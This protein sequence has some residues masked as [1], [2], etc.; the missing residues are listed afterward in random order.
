[1]AIKPNGAKDP[2]PLY[3]KLPISLHVALQEL[4]IKRL[5]KTGTEVNQKGLLEEA[6]RG[7]VEEEGIDLSQIEADV[8]KWNSQQGKRA[9]I[10]TFPRKRG[11]KPS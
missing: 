8:S 7:L 9:K 5:R 6:I 3:A 10:S 4:A 11:R 1:M 2:R